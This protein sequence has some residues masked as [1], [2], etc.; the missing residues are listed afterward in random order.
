MSGVRAWLLVWPITAVLLLLIAVHIAVVPLNSTVT[1]LA[2]LTLPW[3]RDHQPARL[4]QTRLVAGAALRTGDIEPLF[5]LYCGS[6]LWARDWVAATLILFAT[7]GAH[8]PPRPRGHEELPHRV[9]PFIG[10][11]PHVLW[12]AGDRGPDRTRASTERE[13]LVASEHRFRGIF[14][15]TFQFIGLMRTDGTLIE[16][17]RTALEFAGIR[18]AGRDRQAVLGDAVVG[19]L[20]G[21]GSPLVRGDAGSPGRQTRFASRPRIPGPTGAWRTSTSR[22]SRLR[23]ARRRS[24]APDSRGP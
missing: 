1:S 17:N 6:R 10:V 18:E 19:A 21:A 5:G 12:V 3:G 16:A 7:I 13:Q 11:V 14:D 20:A 24:H 2:Q 23:D 22:S 4:R 9:V 15:Q 8:G